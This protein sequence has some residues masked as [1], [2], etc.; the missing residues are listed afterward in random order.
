MKYL[1]E[2]ALGWYGKGN[3]AADKGT[4]VHKFMEIL[5][6]WQQTLQ[7]GE[8][9]FSD[10]IL[11]QCFHDGS[12][13]TLNIDNTLYEYEDI[14]KVIYDHYSTHSVHT[15]TK[16][17]YRECWKWCNMALEFNDGQFNP[18][19]QNIV[20]PEC[21][22][23]I[24]LD[25][26]DWACYNYTVD[27]EEI[28]GFFRLR[29]TIDL[30]IERD[31]NTYEIIDYKTGARKNWATGET[32]DYDNLH[33]NFQLRLYHYAIKQLYPHI[34]NFLS[35]IYYIKD[36]GPFTL[37]FDDSD[38]PKTVEMMRTK[39]E[40]VRDEV[41][42]T[43]KGF[44]CRFCDLKKNTLKTNLVQCLLGPQLLQNSPIQKQRGL[45]LYRSGHQIP[46]E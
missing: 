45:S 34:T 13:N 33:Q 1:G 11:G 15:W 2:Y 28:S 16:K 20:E 26:F 12:T 4:T 46:R 42:R 14:F 41:P 5:A 43:R 38:I 39:F 9:Y 8:Q 7:N 27:E 17:E 24:S 44:H 22:F 30:I 37:A 6:I 21:H 32:Y 23:D 35:T 3:L 19:N 36:G 31:E 25:K 29:G 10:E 40:K 18:F